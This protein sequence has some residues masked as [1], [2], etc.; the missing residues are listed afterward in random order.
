M[1]ITNNFKELYFDILQGNLVEAKSGYNTK[2]KSLQQF[3]NSRN[4]QLVIFEQ[5][6]L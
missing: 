4:V 5:C 1:S 2:S 6:E 3:I